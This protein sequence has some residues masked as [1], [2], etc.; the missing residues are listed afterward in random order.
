MGTTLENRREPEPCSK[1]GSGVLTDGLIHSHLEKIL[2]SSEFIRSERMNSF[3]R[4]VVTASLDG[5]Q[6]N[7]T[8][9]A[10]G[11][12][13]FSK[14]EDWDPSADT[15]VRSEAR[16]LRSKLEVYYE[17]SGQKDEVRIRIPKGRY[18]PEFECRPSLSVSEV[19]LEEEAP[20]VA[21]AKKRWLPVA[22]TSVLIAAV[23]TVAL[24]LWGG[25][26]API[27][28]TSA[29]ESFSILPFTSELGR[30]FSPAIS[31]DGR[32]VAYVWAKGDGGPDIYLRAVE[33][34]SP[35]LMNATP[36][37]RLFP[38][39]SPDGN[40]IAFLQ[41][42]GD[43]VELIVHSLRDGS[44]QKITRIT[45][46]IGQWAGDNS[47]L[48]GAPGPV[49]TKDGKG[50]ILSD[51]DPAKGDGGI[52]LFDLSGRR[53][54][55][56][57]TTGGDHDLYPRLSPDGKVLAYARYSSHGVAELYVQATGTP[58]V[59]HKLTSDKRA[60]QGLTWTPDGRRLIFASNRSGS[61]QL[62][63]ITTGGD[64][65]KTVPTD[66]SSAAEPAMAPS[67]GWLLYVESHVNW[68]IWRETINGSRPL[69][70]QMLI[71]SSGRNYDPRYSPDGQ[72]VAFVSDRSGNMELW[73]AD[74]EGKD[75]RQL[76]HMNAPWL[77]GISWSPDGD[78]IAFDARP[79]GHSALFVIPTSG[80][81]PKLL[82]D[83]A[84][85]E[86]MP[87]WSS[88]GKLLYFN[89][90]RGGSLAA[91]SR[92]LADGSVRR[93]SQAGIFA[94]SSSSQGLVYSSRTGELFASGADG[95]SPVPLMDGLRADPVMS[96]FLVGRN[97]YLSHF[98][99]RTHS[100]SF[101]RYR[102]GRTT[103]IGESGGFLVPNAPDIGVS[104]DERWLV[105]ARQD[106]SQS[107]L[108][109]RRTQ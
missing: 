103:S 15:I 76:T 66:S 56:V 54:I 98:E 33:K 19:S 81:E 55:L 36:S 69:P 16:R 94:I 78:Q 84:Y 100:Y 97:L 102:D 6:A 64:D 80:G 45:K 82:E 89:S 43:Q 58:S 106:S 53:T 70:S 104:P 10:I 72:Q 26:G 107:D 23:L 8:E 17:T 96:W 65:L 79:Q 93:I 87:S 67:G 9:R 44:E 99:E 39:W 25:H 95:R 20:V 32:T 2:R 21:P 12:E 38:A 11:R 91:W 62:W 48:I 24:W 40:Q 105:Y 47:P 61:F 27:A 50:L 86:R 37:V 59:P 42:M 63:S 30:E 51:Y 108:K 71:S 5:R 46:Q 74:G 49:W 34:G 35:H 60:I 88:D 109:I 18:V 68:N 85:E 75:E 1:A 41:V 22:V 28:S 52:F 90:N 57:V 4:Y 31:P 92:S 101:L 83:N 77:G 3:L 29:R 73:V 7:L 13:V 14:A